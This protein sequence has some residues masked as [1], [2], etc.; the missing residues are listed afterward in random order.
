MVL[1]KAACFQRNRRK[2]EALLKEKEIQRSKQQPPK[3]AQSQQVET[4][5]IDPLLLDLSSDV[6]LIDDED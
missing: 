3:P 2:R 6:M 4:A 1:T 5:N